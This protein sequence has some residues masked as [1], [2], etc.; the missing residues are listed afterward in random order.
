[1]IFRRYSNEILLEMTNESIPFTKTDDK[2]RCKY[3]DFV[4][5]CGRD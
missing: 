5:I 1:M 3:C 2:E 4:K